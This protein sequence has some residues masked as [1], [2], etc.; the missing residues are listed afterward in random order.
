MTVAQSTELVGTWKS[1]PNDV[2][3]TAAYGEVSLKFFAD[4]TIP[5]A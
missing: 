3:G 1:D 2:A 5:K 4:G